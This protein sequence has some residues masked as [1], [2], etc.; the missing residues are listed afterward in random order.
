MFIPELPIFNLSFKVRCPA[1]A[2][3]MG[4]HIVRDRFLCPF[5][6]KILRS[7]KKETINKAVIIAIILYLLFALAINFISMK[8]WELLATMIAAS[9]T[10]I[11]AGYTYFKIYFK[12]TQERGTP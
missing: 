3:K 7:N 1:C 8:E 6:K 4:G 2:E 9:F 12:V 10:P 5:C 11:L